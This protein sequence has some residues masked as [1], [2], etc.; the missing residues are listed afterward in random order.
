MCE[1]EI[2]SVLGDEETRD[3]LELA[4]ICSQHEQIPLDGLISNL[5]LRNHGSRAAK[6]FLFYEDRQ[7]AGFLGMALRPNGQEVQ[8]SGI[9]HPGQRRKKIAT[10]MYAEA[11]KQ[12]ETNLFEKQYLIC[13]PASLSGKGFLQS[14]GAAYQFTEYTLSYGPHIFPP[15]KKN[16]LEL[17]RMDSYDTHGAHRTLMNSF[18]MSEED[19]VKQINKYQEGK[20]RQIYVAK[21]SIWS[22]GIMM[23]TKEGCDVFVDSIAIQP[24]FR[25]KGYGKQMVL[26]TIEKIQRDEEA[27]VNLK[28]RAE[29]PSQ[30]QLFKSCGFIEN[31]AYDYYSF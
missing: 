24:F 10:N 25:K 13:H 21:L 12:T 22:V 27:V 28:I 14:I 30:L 19:A 17:R 7:L 3:V 6:A 5:L 29:D 15:G 8:L 26:Q 16:I 9:V 31:A 18:G 1:L 4:Q 23:V 20:G 11:K 2:K